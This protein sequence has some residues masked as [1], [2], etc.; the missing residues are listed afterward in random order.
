MC[1]GHDLGS[2]PAGA[3]SRGRMHPRGE[4]PRLSWR[5]ALACNCGNGMLP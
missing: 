3:G 4:V 1:L 2:I 5:R